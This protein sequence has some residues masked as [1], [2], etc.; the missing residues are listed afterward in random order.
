M[1]RG[2]FK[3]WTAVTNA[4]KDQWTIDLVQFYNHRI[5]LAYKG[6][7]SG[8]FFE[9]DATGKFDCGF[10]SVAIPHIGDAFFTIEF[11]KQFASQND[12]IEYIISIQSEF[13]AIIEDFSNKILKMI[14][15]RIS[16]K[17]C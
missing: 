1:T 8:K 4:S 14:S 12:A 3:S 10:Y 7:Q 13:G 17:I 2:E 9:I 5:L 11:T 15:D 16:K 6:G